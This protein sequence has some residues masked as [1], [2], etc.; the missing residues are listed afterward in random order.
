[1]TLS[2]EVAVRRIAK[3]VAGVVRNLKRRETELLHEIKLRKNNEAKLKD[4]LRDTA[5]A[6]AAMRK[7]LIQHGNADTLGERVRKSSGAAKATAPGDS[8]A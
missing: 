4:Q 8:E 6:A 1:M 3:E 7:E 2:S 5:R